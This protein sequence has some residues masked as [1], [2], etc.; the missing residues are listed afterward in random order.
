MVRWHPV[1]LPPKRCDHRERAPAGW[2]PCSVVVSHAAEAVTGWPGDRRPSGSSS[3]VKRRGRGIGRHCIAGG[4]AFTVGSPCRAGATCVI[5]GPASQEAPGW[6]G[7]WTQGRYRRQNVSRSTWPTSSSR[8]STGGDRLTPCSQLLTGA[9]FRPHHE[10]ED[11]YGEKGEILLSHLPARR[12]ADDLARHVRAV[13]APVQEVHPATVWIGL[14][15]V[16]LED[17]E[18]LLPGL[19]DRGNC[20]GCAGRG[21]LLQD[22]GD[23]RPLGPVLLE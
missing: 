10:G 9:G 6:S 8:V 11:G 17:G 7:V 23:P 2:V 16:G 22:L 5:R 3:K 19:L 1:C 13:E 21:P 20:Y 12:G 18:D 14:L 4:R 15:A